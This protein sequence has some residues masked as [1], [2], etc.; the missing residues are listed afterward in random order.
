MLPHA[1]FKIPPWLW[2]GCFEKL[3]FARNG[4][5]RLSYWKKVEATQ[6]WSEG[7][8]R[9]LQW[10]RLKAMLRFIYKNNQFYKSR[11]QSVGVHPDQVRAPEEISKLPVLTKKEI[12]LNT[13]AM[14]S[15]GYHMEDLICFKTGGSTGKAL[16]LFITEECSELRNACARRHDRWTG[17]E[18]GEAIGALW[19][20]PKRPKSLR[21][22]MVDRLVQPVIYL[23]T[24]EF[25]DMSVQRFAE[26]WGTAQPTL[27]F[28]HAHSIFLLANHV[29]RMNIRI[30]RPKGI[31]S[32]SMMLL[33]HERDVIEKVFK[34]KV[35]DRYG[36]EEV[37][38]IAS[39]CEQ[40][41]G[42]H[43][44]IEHLYIEFLKEDGT[45]AGPGEEGQIVVTDLMNKAMPFIR[46]RVEDVGVPS[47]KKCDC[48]RGLPLMER[49]AGRVA[50]FL[51]RPDGSK[52][53][54]ISLIENTLT[55]IPGIDQMQIVQEEVGSIILNIVRGPAFT[56][57][58]AEDLAGY[59]KSLFGEGSR[60]GINIIEE[61]KPERSG[62]YRFSICRVDSSHE[63]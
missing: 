22:K 56:T 30:I 27:L 54:G 14:I 45:A 34:V 15:S 21:E 55:R 8:L 37:S 28:G 17:W 40:H 60:V 59:F 20:N 7:K 48:G 16:E 38:L 29:K 6:H 49:V 9:E 1:S 5:K 44:N 26:E 4:S 50:D 39:E 18:P 2:R 52:V 57:D 35:F 11:F 10:Q 13:P 33:P 24:M 36:C 58:T 25:S 63:A 47:D 12:R 41:Q 43:L 42:M 61:I 23:D 32:T 3:Y 31:L 51:I 46:Y 19:G 62:K 53:A